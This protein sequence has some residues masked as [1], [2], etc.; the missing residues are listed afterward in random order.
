MRWGPGADAAK[1][2]AQACR[3]LAAANPDLRDKAQAALSC[4]SGATSPTCRISLKA[5]P[6]SNAN[7]PADLKRQW[8]TPDGHARVEIAP[9]GDVND[10]EVLRTFART[11]LAAYPN[12]VGGPISIFES[13]NTV[14]RA[15]IEA[16]AYALFSIAIL[17]WIVLR[18]FG[19]VL[20][21]LVPL[22]LGRR[23][24]A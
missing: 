22:L 24:N 6:V 21:T 20:L 13:G 17:L 11:I 16:G 18:R 19:D 9:K 8:V 15:F 3:K 2:L 7:L 12:A 4:R 23:R 5:Q 10:T 1:R 14:V